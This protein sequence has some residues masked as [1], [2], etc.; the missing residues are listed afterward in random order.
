LHGI[1][2]NAMSMDETFRIKII[3][4]RKM[5]EVMR[6]SECYCHSLRSLSNL[7]RWDKG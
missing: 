6:G 2:K 1:G 7:D 4:N 3:R 5:A